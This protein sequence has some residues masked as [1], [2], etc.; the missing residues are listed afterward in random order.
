MIE[1]LIYDF[2]GTIS[3]SYAMFLDFWTEVAEKYAIRIPISRE[4]L[5]RELKKTGYDAYL[6]LDCADTIDYDTFLHEFYLLQEAHRLDF[7]PF[8]AAISLLRDAKAAGKK[9][10]LYTHTGPV[11]KDMLANMGIADCFE[12]ILD[13]SYG[14]PLKPA[15]DALRFLTQRFALDPTTCLMIGDRPI[16]ALAG[17]NAGMQGCLWDAEGLFD[18]TGMDYY[19][20]DL[21]DVARIAGF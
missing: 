17:Q 6:A 13:S 16:D 12:F 11:V 15:P 4:E 10:Y 9:N 20:K 21:S 18:E 1:H 19:I 8:P 2:D 5:Y 3:D 14:F 7:K